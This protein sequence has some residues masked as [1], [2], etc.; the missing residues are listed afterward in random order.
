MA[1]E[2]KAVGFL[3]EVAGQGY[4][5]VGTGDV[6]TPL[7]LVAQQ[8]SAVVDG[9][10]VE[11][12]HFYNSITGEDYGTS[13][14]L[15]I[16][17][18]KKMWYEWKPNQGGLAGIHEVGG[19]EVTGDVFTGMKTAE[20]NK[21]EEKMVFLVVL[22]DHPEAGYMIFG[23]TPGI[24]KYTKAWLTQAQNLRLPSGARAPLFGAVWSVEL[25]KNTSK[26]GN[27]YYAP[28]IDGKSSFKFV[29]WIPEVLYRDSVL[30]AREI[31]SQALALA[32]NRSM[33]QQAIESSTAEANY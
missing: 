4:E 9:G 16:C 6:T 21:V 11:V 14:K 27:K 32:D 29:E 23:S 1:Q 2:E 13:L 8:L 3:D 26:D 30:P 15:V 12:G 22:P 28:A 19:I 24:M 20:G 17:H 7:L 25:A 5:N 18:Y 33:E 10:S 31:A